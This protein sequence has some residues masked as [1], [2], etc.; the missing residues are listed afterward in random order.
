[1]RKGIIGA[2][3]WIVDMIKTIDRFPAVGE[4]CNILSQEV[5]GGGGPCNVLFDLAAMEVDFPLYA[6]GRI[7]V[8]GNGDYLYNEIK[9]RNINSELIIRDKSQ[10]T[11]F[12]DVMSGNG[13][14]TFF[15]SRGANANVCYED[16]LDVNFDAKI[17]YLGYLLLLDKLDSADAE[18][19]TVGAKVLKLMKNKGYKTLVDFVSEAPEKFRKVVKAALPYIDYLVINEIE[20]GNT[21]EENIRLADDSLDFEAME[22]TALKFFE[23]GV[24]ELVVFHYPEGAFVMKKGEKSQT[25]ASGKI[26]KKDIV[27]TN[28]AGDAFCAGI[29]YGLHEELPVEEMIEVANWS[30]ICNLSSPSAS[31]G[32]KSLKLMNK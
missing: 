15:A 22:R 28:G 9:K 21:F 26:D 1:M 14:R 6:V 27:G 29:L 32:A 18:Y 4:L 12:T 25:F 13:K 19:G 10:P 31:G 2:G 8:D 20:A 7:G 11:S 16:F 23:A 30:A 3:N 17:F 24:K 5:A